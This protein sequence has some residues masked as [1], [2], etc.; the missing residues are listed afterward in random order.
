MGLPMKVN[1]FRSEKALRSDNYSDH[2][3]IIVS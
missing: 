1:P 3:I 2:N